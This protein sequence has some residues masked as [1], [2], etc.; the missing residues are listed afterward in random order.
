MILYSTGNFDD[1]SMQFTTEKYRE[2][3]IILQEQENID[4]IDLT[5]VT[6]NYID[7]FDEYLSTYHKTLDGLER[8]S[9]QNDTLNL[10][11]SEKEHCDKILNNADELVKHFRQRFTGLGITDLNTT[12]STSQQPFLRPEY[13]MYIDR[14]GLPI[15]GIFDSEKMSAILL[16]LNVLP[17]SYSLI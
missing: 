3:G 10:F 6:Y 4:N 7:T 8:S 5:G 15:G 1:L 13:Q 9:V 16:E 11:K 12:V 17:I 14:H 2:L